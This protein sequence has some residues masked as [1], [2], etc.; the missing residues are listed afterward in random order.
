MKLVS[1]SQVIGHVLRLAMAAV[2]TSRM[3]IFH[4]NEAETLRGDGL[5]QIN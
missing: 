1:R 5:S 2:F 3:A 4:H